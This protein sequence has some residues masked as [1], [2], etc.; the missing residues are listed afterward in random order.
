M[1][2][3]GAL[4]QLSL[5][6]SFEDEAV[7]GAAGSRATRFRDKEVGMAPAE[8]TKAPSLRFLAQLI[9]N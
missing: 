2:R 4:L 5:S 6:G 8:V 9:K 1:D 7:E 3:E